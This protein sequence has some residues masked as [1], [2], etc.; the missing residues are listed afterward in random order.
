MVYQWLSGSLQVIL[1]FALNPKQH[2]IE[3]AYCGATA[4]SLHL[5][6][7]LPNE[8]RPRAAAQH[9]R[10]DSAN[11][12]KHPMGHAVLLFKKTTWNG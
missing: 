10:S 9:R 5:R 11:V 4:V 12:P 2:S 7:L 3:H 8:A 6:Q 1:N